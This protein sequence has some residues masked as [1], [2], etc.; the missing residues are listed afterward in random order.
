MSFFTLSQ[1]PEMN[2]DLRSSL[3][4]VTFLTLLTGVAYPLSVTKIGQALF[5]YQAKGSLIKEGDTIIGSPLIGQN[6]S[7]DRYF[8]GRPSAAGSGYDANNSSGSNLGASSPKLAETLTH[9]VEEL[10]ASGE[11]RRIPVDLVTAS[12]SGLDPDISIASARY[13][14]QRIADA[15]GLPL[16][17]IEKLID[18][19]TTPRTFGFL[20]E[21]RVN[22][23]QI[24]RALDRLAPA[25]VVEPVV[26]EPPSPDAP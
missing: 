18:L 23:L 24:N 22:V 14:A 6:F 7:S 21:K 10:R 17:K 11:T 20:G 12:A 15:R 1:E 9:R 26:P 19:T 5:P 4:L 2:K 25:P 8:H 13:Q 16:P 3:G